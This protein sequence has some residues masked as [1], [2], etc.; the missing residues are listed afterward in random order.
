MQV[1]CDDVY[2]TARPHLALTP[3]GPSRPRYRRR[4]EG[5]GTKPLWR[6]F[7]RVVL[8]WC[9]ED[10][11]DPA[12]PTAGPLAWARQV[13]LLIGGWTPAVWGEVG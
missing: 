10:G 7:V 11:P 13:K 2:V 12:L 9:S 5:M 3:V 1:S 6:Y 8:V 4:P